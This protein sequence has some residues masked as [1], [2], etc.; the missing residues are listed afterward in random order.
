MDR[1]V[2]HTLLTLLN[3]R[4]AV[5]LPGQLFG[6]AVDFFQRL[7]NRHGPDRHRRIADDPLAGFMNVF[8]GGQIHHR[9]AAPADR[10]GHF[11]DFFLNAGGQRRVADI[12]VDF[13]QEVAADDHRLNFRMVDVHRD[14]GAAAGHFI[15]NEFRRDDFRNGRAEVMTRML[16]GQQLGKPLAPLVLADRDVFH[17][18]R[19]H[20]FTRIVHLRHVHAGLGN[21]RLAGEIEAQAGK[22]RVGQTFL[23]VTR[24][25]TI[26]GN[27]I[28]ALLDPLLPQRR[29]TGADINFCRGIGVRSRSV[30]H[31]NRRIFFSTH[32]G[33]GVRL[34]DFAHRHLNV[35]AGTRYVDLARIRQ[36]FHRAGINLG[37]GIEELRI[38]IHFS[39]SRG[40]VGRSGDA[41]GI[42]EPFPKHST[43]PYDGIIRI[44]L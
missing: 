25:G 34:R 30:I 28:A 14:N 2:V 8:A 35:G 13:D 9:V 26:Q 16:F 17:L 15:T 24:A 1:K 32:R 21:P 4:I 5:N 33:R 36:R 12:G 19:D 20:A 41:G 44:R 39:H 23:T 22:L 38:G 11:L 6:L 27:G 29:Q 43:L 10:P 3:Q 7:I 40:K 37:S 42:K 18:R 31:K